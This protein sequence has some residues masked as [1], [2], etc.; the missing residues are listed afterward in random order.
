MVGEFRRASWLMVAAVGFVLLI[1]CANVANLLLARGA[2]RQREFAIRTA[3]GAGRARVIQQLMI[4]SLVVGA[5]SGAAGLLISAWIIDLT[6]RLSTINIPL[7]ETA[8]LRWSGYWSRPS[9]HSNRPR[10]RNRAGTAILL[11]AQRLAPRKP[12]VSEDRNGRRWRSALVTAEV[13]LT[14]VLLVGAGLMITSFT[15]LIGV[16]PGFRPGMC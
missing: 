7:L 1:G 14:L 4:E 2:N 16:D 13:G 3:L 11:R 5:L 6:P 12:S 10:R 9:P 15:R 8:R